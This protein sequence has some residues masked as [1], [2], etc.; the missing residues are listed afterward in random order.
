[1]PGVNE[2]KVSAKGRVRLPQRLLDRW[3]LEAGS[4]VG[5]V[6]LG[7]AALV[8][9][10]GLG[11][12]L[13][14]AQVVT[15]E[16]SGLADGHDAGARKWPPQ[17]DERISFSVA[18]EV[19]SLP[20]GPHDEFGTAA[21]WI[22]QTISEGYA[23]DDAYETMDL[24]TATVWGLLHGHGVRA[25]VGN[26]YHEA[27]M[28]L[29]KENEAP[30]VAE[31]AEVLATPIEGFGLYRYPNRKARFISEAVSRLGS[32]T[33]PD[34]PARLR[35]YLLGLRGVGP[36]T[37]ALIES[38][39]RGARA[40]VHVN[41]IWL[42]RALIPAGVFPAPTGTSRSTTTDSRRRSS[43]TRAT[44]TSHPPPWTGASG[45]W[46]ARKDPVPSNRPTE[47]LWHS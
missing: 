37:A 24:K 47:S 23:D 7:E 18:G 45:N 22:D 35:D 32:D 41:D 17:A 10:G 39:F 9:P 34:D 1:M 16:S 3:G 43:N 15:T 4:R 40:E 6:D 46:H 26:A 2:V 19:W 25:E 27:V 13:V 11:H 20:W 21:Y 29:L 8:V 28:E 44:E 33:P 38:G 30:S 36:K 14:E 12:L 31:V 42:R 5:L